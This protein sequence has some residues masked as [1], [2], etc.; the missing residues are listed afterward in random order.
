MKH[1]S[2]S[3]NFAFQQ[4]NSLE[5]TFIR[6]RNLILDNKMMKIASLTL[7]IFGMFA[8]IPVFAEEPILI[9]HNGQE[10]GLGGS[11]NGIVT[12]DGKF[13]VFMSFARNLVVDPNLQADIFIKDLSTGEIQLVSVAIEELG[14][15][16]DSSNPSISSDGQ[17]I[18][19]VSR[20]SNLVSGDTNDASDVFVYDRNAD[21]VSR[22]SVSSDG[23]QGNGPSYDSFISP[24][25][26]NVLFFSEATNFGSS[27]TIF[28]HNL[29]TGQ[30]NGID[31][32][33]Y[34]YF[35]V[36]S[37]SS[38]GRYVVFISDESNLVEQDQSDN[39]DIFVY[40]TQT[41]EINFVSSPHDQSQTEEYSD[42]P[43][44]SGNGKY[45]TF[46]SEAPNLVG[47]DQ[48]DNAVSLFIRDLTS[49]TT[50]LIS[51]DETGAQIKPDFGISQIS[52]DGNTIVF[53]QEGSPS[54]MYVYDRLSGK[55]TKL[56]SLGDISYLSPD[57]KK[58]VFHSDES[59]VTEDTNDVS[60]V[61]LLDISSLDGQ[62][63]VT[64]PPEPEPTPAPEPEPTPAPEPEPT[65]EEAETVEIPDFI[66][67]T[68]GWWSAGEIG[69][70]DFVSGIQWLIENGIMK[71]PLTESGE[72][73]T[74][75]IPDYIR[76]TAGWWS[77]GL[78]GDS[79]FVSG[80]QWLI[81]NGIMK[82]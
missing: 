48:N 12:D 76:N 80:I 5:Q 21:Q 10:V 18:A 36:K 67:N 23:Q 74:Q 69:D 71:I 41:G 14:A 68:A 22:I 31:Y 3:I 63:V 49:G 13:V 1:T 38:D 57:G 7:I 78:I 43:S 47:N 77:E 61:Y 40:D 26:K 44:I 20:A 81:E 60:D 30:T 8:I 32:Y 54:Y 50:D 59:L 79:D 45:V 65:T 27:G 15:N 25:G 82:I 70:S 6:K 53:S 35:C 46:V 37:I 11:Y 42:M 52:N 16:D 58:L 73:S 72:G 19:F 62:S 17:Y 56:S 66:R 28:I 55:S 33:G 75:D 9:S 64:P 29:E 2:P 34:C 51:L 24:D 4:F 39:D